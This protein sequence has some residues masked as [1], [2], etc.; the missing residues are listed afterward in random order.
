MYAVVQWF[1]HAYKGV[2][3]YLSAGEVATIVS[4]AWY[5]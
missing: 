5:K 3:Y 4:K 2:L 1:H